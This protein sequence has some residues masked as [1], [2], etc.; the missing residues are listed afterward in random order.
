MSADFIAGMSD[1]AFSGLSEMP[2][3]VTLTSCDSTRF[4]KTFAFLSMSS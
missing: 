1:A 3:E 4:S 2:N